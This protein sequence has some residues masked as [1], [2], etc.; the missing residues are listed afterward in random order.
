MTYPAPPPTPA[1]M[2]QVAMDKHLKSSPEFD[3]GQ[4]NELAAKMSPG[5]ESATTL[6]VEEAIAPPEPSP[7]PMTRPPLTIPPLTPSSEM[8]PVPDEEGDEPAFKPLSEDDLEVNGQTLQGPLNLETPIEVTA[9]Y[10]EFDERRQIFTA[11]GNV[12]MRYRDS[13]LDADRLEVNLLTRMARGQGNVAL[14]L[15][16]QVLRGEEFR[17]NFVQQTGEIRQ[18]RGEVTS[19]QRLESATEA[20]I[21]LIETPGSTLLPVA[22]DAR[23]LTDGP[24]SDRIRDQQPLR[25]SPG[26][27]IE[28]G[29]GGGQGLPGTQGAGTI[30]NFRFEAGEVTFTAQGWEAEDVSITNDPFSPP[31]L[32]I[33]ADRARLRSIDP[34]RDELRLERP[35]LV[36]D[37]N[38]SIGIPRRRFIFDRREQ[39]EP[40]LQIG[41]DGRDRGGLFVQRRF[42]LVDTPVFSLSVTPQY[43]VEQ[44][45]NDNNVVKLDNF[46]TVVQARGRFSPTTI[47]TADVDVLNLDFAEFDSEEDLR[48]SARLSQLVGDHTL[49]GEYG[50]RD[51]LFNGSLGFQ[52][53]YSS[54]GAVLSS[55]Q[56]VLGSTGISLNYQVGVNRIESDTDDLSLLEPIRENNRVS[57]TRYQGSAV[58]RRGFTLWQGEALPLTA[59]EGLRYTPV[60]VV[61]FVQAYVAARGIAGFYSNG[62][63]ETSLQGTVGM[64]AQFGHFSRNVLDYTSLNI[65]YSETLGSGQS[66]FL[67]DR[68]ADPRVLRLGLVQQI[69]G[70]FRAGVQTSINL[71]S[72]ESFSTNFTLEYS[73]RTYGVTIFVNPQQEIGGLS[74]RISDFDWNGNTRSFSNPERCAVR[75]G[76]RCTR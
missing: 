64:Q 68:I 52:T 74:L 10:Q 69:Y 1:P 41:Y 42:N 14:A 48:A 61:P 20:E 8:F 65:E 37:D 53:V 33:R 27:N 21:G 12:V 22:V 50:F 11:V 39:Q 23:G 75:G 72:G 5:D 30:S 59:E 15:P 67:F 29:V 13:V 28:L 46:G 70:P 43:F 54:F 63:S 44:G 18:A 31:E 9:D 19:E 55:P 4:V 6:T 38:F 40:F 35:R 56:Y 16:G 76:L 24:Q 60:P 66:P 36:F 57:L 51:R 47:L 26:G 49:T 17:Y 7:V 34:L 25:V 2:V 62:D 71:D 58:L 32:E 45:I 3:L 73:R